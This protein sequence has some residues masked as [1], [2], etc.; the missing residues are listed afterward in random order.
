MRFRPVR[1]LALLPALLLGA[2]ISIQVATTVAT[3]QAVI[4]GMMI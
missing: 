3:T 4:S 2:F 1:F